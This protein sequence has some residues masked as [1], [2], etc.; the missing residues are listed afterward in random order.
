MNQDN[1]DADE[2]LGLIFLLNYPHLSTDLDDSSCFTGLL[3]YYVQ[4]TNTLQ[5]ELAVVR[6]KFAPTFGLQITNAS[7]YIG[8]YQW[9][10]VI[11]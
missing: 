2:H 6:N 5:P 3:W 4:T 7:A 1:R 9:N 10:I 11:L 8:F